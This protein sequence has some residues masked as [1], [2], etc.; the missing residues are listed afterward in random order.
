MTDKTKI[1][2]ILNLTE[3]SFSDGQIYLDENKAFN[4][5]EKMI[6]EGCKI[7]DIGAEST[8]SGFATIADDIQLE[9][10]LPIIKRIKTSY[11]D[12]KISIDTRS[13]NVADIVLTEGASIINDVSAGEHDKNMFSIISKHNA[14]VII[15]HMPEEHLRKKNMESEDIVEDL[16]KYFTQRISKA[17]A[18]G[19]SE[20]KI[21]VDPGISFG[22]SGEDNIKIIKNIEIFVKKFERVCLGVS[23]KRFSSKIFSQLKDKDM[24]IASLVITAFATYK[25]VMF[26]RVHNVSAN[27]DALEVAWKT[28]QST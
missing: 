20:K 27:S 10:L 21:I 23:N 24:H 26:L 14:E 19:I 4:H 12:V 11:D 28:H 3:D 9:R 22:K 18:S 15:T 2:G 5:I 17:I 8:R 6:N 25:G 1:I 13:G 16:L 7:I